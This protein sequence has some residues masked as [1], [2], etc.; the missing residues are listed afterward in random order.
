MNTELDQEQHSPE[1]PIGPL[2][3]L[4]AMVPGTTDHVAHPGGII[5]FDLPPSPFAAGIVRR[6]LLSE[7]GTWCAPD[8][9]ATMYPLFESWD[10]ILGTVLPSPRQQNL[11]RG[12][13][14]FWPKGTGSYGL[15]VVVITDQSPFIFSDEPLLEPGIFVLGLNAAHADL[16]G[17][18]A[19]LHR[20]RQIASEYNLGYVHL[21]LTFSDA[22]ELETSLRQI[23]IH[24][25]SLRTNE[26]PVT[27]ITMTV[28]AE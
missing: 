27:I 12:L 23:T 20:L 28:P 13:G 25:T 11:P 9:H 7:Y 24:R 14:V 6:E 22:E 10:S 19:L 8:E 18:S 15:D 5:T 21:I 16:A 1:P 26:K 17:R 4:K 2:A 3:V